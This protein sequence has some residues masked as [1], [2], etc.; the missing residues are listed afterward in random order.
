MHKQQQIVLLQLNITTAIGFKAEGN[1]VAES[2][3]GSALNLTSVFDHILGY[4]NTRVMELAVA[5]VNDNAL[6]GAENF[7]TILTQ[8]RENNVVAGTSA[9]YLPSYAELKLMQDNY[10]VV[11]AS[12]TKVG[13]FITTIYRICKC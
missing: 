13:G 11:S 9:W 12:M 6:T 10:A 7:I 4:N 2:Y 3:I 1:Q 5:D 8:Y